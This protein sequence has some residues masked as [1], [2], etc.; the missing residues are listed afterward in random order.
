MENEIICNLGR[1]SGHTLDAKASQ[2]G[3]TGHGLHGTGSP[4]GDDCQGHSQLRYVLTRNADLRRLHFGEIPDSS[5]T[6]ANGLRQ[7]S[8]ASE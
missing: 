4:A 7:T 6:F 1:L 3:A 5:G 8:G 2:D